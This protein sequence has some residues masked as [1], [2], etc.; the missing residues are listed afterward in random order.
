MILKISSFGFQRSGIPVD[1]DK[2]IDARAI[3]NPHLDRRLR[4]RTGLD[5][6]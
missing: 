2:V 5:K 6:E 4:L 1:A 3:K